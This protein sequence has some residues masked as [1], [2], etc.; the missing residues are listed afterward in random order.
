MIN[1]AEAVV[2]VNDE[3]HEVMVWPHKMGCPEDYPGGRAGFWCDPIGA[4]YVEWDKLSNDDRMGLMTETV[5]DLA[6]QGC[7]LKDVLTAFAQV[8]EFRALGSK[9]Y[10]MARALTSALL[11]RCLE[12]T[13]EEF[14][15]V[16]RTY[17][18][19]KLISPTRA[20]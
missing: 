16:M 15:Y 14:E 5:I 18:S 7:A 19:R 17:P 3:T 20:E 11:G 4:A 1:A 13:G 10:P 6:M 8:V 12:P 9:S 2:W